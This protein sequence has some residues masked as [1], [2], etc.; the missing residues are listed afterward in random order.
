MQWWES[1]KLGQ[2]CN[3]TIYIGF[4]SVGNSIPEFLYVLSFLTYISVILIWTRNYLRF[5]DLSPTFEKSPRALMFFGLH[6]VSRGVGWYTLNTVKNFAKIS[7]QCSCYYGSNILRLNW[8]ENWYFELIV[9]SDIN[10]L[11]AILL[12][13]LYRTCLLENIRM[14]NYWKIK[15][16]FFLTV[17]FCNVFKTFCTNVKYLDSSEGYFRDLDCYELLGLKARRLNAIFIII[18][19]RAL[20]EIFR[21]WRHILLG[22]CLAVQD[23]TKWIEGYVLGTFWRICGWIFCLVGAFFSFSH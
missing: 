3:R 9:D 17:L 8:C 11:I 4:F 2:K 7:L 6:W 13:S 1:W 10:H 23:K 20:S 16:E 22:G 21:D 19:K 5:G 18:L 12:L 15:F 14:K